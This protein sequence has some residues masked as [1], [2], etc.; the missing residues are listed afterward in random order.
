MRVIALVLFAVL[1]FLQYRLWL[2]EGGMREVWRLRSEIEAQRLEIDTLRE[3]NSTLAAEVQDLKKGR[4][5][6]EERARTDL[7]MVAR[8]ETFFQ[9]A[10]SEEPEA[11][12]A[13]I[14]DSRA[15]QQ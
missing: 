14:D 7:G 11:A 15:R 2:S 13:A 3:R 5:A 9:V 10:P 4:T 6:V 1:V 8:G 12:D